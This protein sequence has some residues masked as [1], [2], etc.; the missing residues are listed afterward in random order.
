MQIH[1]IIRINTQLF[2]IRLHHQINTSPLQTT[3]LHNQK[4]ETQ[5]LTNALPFIPLNQTLKI[6]QLTLHT[7]INLFFLLNGIT[8]IFLIKKPSST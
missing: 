6:L 1:F 5:T 4:R 3:R 7:F 2:K 8:L